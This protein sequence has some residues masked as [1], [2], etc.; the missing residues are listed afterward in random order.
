[1]GTT[2]MHFTAETVY[3]KEIPD[4]LFERR[5]KYTRVSRDEIDK[6]MN[7]MISL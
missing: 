1:M 7:K 2:E 6:F 4:K 5:E 3:K